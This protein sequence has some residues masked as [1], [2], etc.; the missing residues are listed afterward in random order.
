M[1]N[2]G[3]RLIGSSILAAGGGVTLSLGMLAHTPGQEGAL[4]GLAMLLLGVALF[5]VD[6]LG[7][8]REDRRV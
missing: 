6:W 5:A 1:S 7:S 8:W 4:A 2:R 3:Y